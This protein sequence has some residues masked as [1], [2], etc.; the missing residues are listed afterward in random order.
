[1]IRIAVRKLEDGDPGTAILLDEVNP[2]LDEVE[3][4]A[5]DFFLSRGAGT[6]H[7][8]DDWLRAERE[9]LGI[10]PAELIDTPAAFVLRM[11][12]PGLLPGEI[13]VTATPRELVVK[14]ASPAAAQPLGK[15]DHLCWSELRPCGTFCRRI[16]LPLAIDTEDVTATLES[17]ILRIQ[18]AKG[19][20]PEIAE[21]AA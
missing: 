17:G 21:A 14:A 10:P 7:A 18:A 15:E 9:T 1:M 2:M 11:A 3:R 12:L 6:G 16:P 8:L 5:F 19:G 13:E 4:R 20:E